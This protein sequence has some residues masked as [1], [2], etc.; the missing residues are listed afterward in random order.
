VLKTMTVHELHAFA[1]EVPSREQLA[2][3]PPLTF[4]SAV[5]PHKGP[6]RQVEVHVRR[7]GTGRRSQWQWLYHD[8]SRIIG[9]EETQEDLT[10][11]L[12]HDLQNPLSNVI[13]SLELIRA[14]LSDEDS[15]SVLPM[16]DVAIRSSNQLL[17]MIH[18]LLDISRLEAGQA[19]GRQE[20]V[21]LATLVDEVYELELPIFEQRE[22]RFVRKLEPG[23]PEVYVK[24][25]MIRR[26]LINL[27]ENAIKFGSEKQQITVAARRHGDKVVVSVSDQGRGV[28]GRYRE[29]IFEKFE[30]VKGQSESPGLGLGLAFCR[31]AVEAHGGRI[32]VDDAPGGGARFSF[33][34]PVAHGE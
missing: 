22:T 27:T 3:A 16:L 14:D 11:M 7:T 5:Y 24:T 10:A 20:A 18:S 30:R 4:I 31:L 32:W 1:N 8:I 13:T 34:L 25:D 9:L 15:E 33:S 28:P 17:F 26:V 19:L 2:A 23:L 6:A 29:T 21:G 12:V